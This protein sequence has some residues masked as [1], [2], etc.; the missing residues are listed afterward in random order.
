MTS[1]LSLTP[2]NGEMR[3]HDLLLAERLGFSRPTD[4]RKIIK[5]YEKKLKQINILATMAQIHEGAG[6]PTTEFYLDQKQAMFICMKSE[7]DTAFDVQVDILNV[8]NAYVNGDLKPR[9]PQPVDPTMAT[10]A[11]H[12]IRAVQVRHSKLANAVMAAMGGADRVKQYNYKNV[13][14]QSGKSPR[15]WKDQA[16]Y[17]GMKARNRTSG[18]EVL[19]IKLPHVACGLSLADHLVAG[20]AA[21]HDGISI[22]KDAQPIFQRILA[23]GITP[24]ELLI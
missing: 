18:K 1:S 16:K 9:S 22:G 8:Y 2:I 3:I 24:P 12:T 15:E 19:R 6:R 17:E 7:T 10:L 4:I 20:G 21:E 5:R 11:G 14:I 13:V 23:L